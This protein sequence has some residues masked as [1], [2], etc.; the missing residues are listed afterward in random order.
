MQGPGLGEPVGQ[1][2]VLGQQVHVVHRDVVTAGVRLAEAD[3]DQVSAVKP[4]RNRYFG[5]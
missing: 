1:G 2:G 4:D 3:I 5:L